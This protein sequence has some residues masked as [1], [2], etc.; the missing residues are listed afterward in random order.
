LEENQK[1]KVEAFKQ[2][3]FAS[4]DLI[5]VM[6]TLSSH[7]FE[8]TESTGVYVGA[9]EKPKKPIEEDSTDVDHI[10]ETAIEEIKFF[11]AYP[12]N[13]E[14]MHDQVIKRNEGVVH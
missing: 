12:Q 7:L 8:F 9:L 6:P 14:F 2:T 4:D 13:H 3:V 1:E 10:D 5:D 11:E